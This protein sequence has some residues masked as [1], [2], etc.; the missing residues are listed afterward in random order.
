M[1]KTIMIIVGVVCLAVGAFAGIKIYEH[2]KSKSEEV[3][4]KLDKEKAKDEI[5]AYFH[6]FGGCDGGVAL[7]F[8]KKDKLYYNDLE[9]Y[10]IYDILYSYMV[11]NNLVQ[12]NKIDSDIGGYELS[13]STNSLETA[14]TNIFGIDAKNNFKL[15]NVFNASLWQF[16]LDEKNHVYKAETYATGCE[17]GVNA[18]YL[19]NYDLIEKDKKFFLDFVYYYIDAMSQENNGEVETFDGAFDPYHT[20]KFICK[21]DDIKNHLNEFDKYRY[22]FKLEN[23]HFILDYIEKIN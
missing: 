18:Y 20:D 9:V 12:E 7:D 22:N 11:K 17:P 4:I 2:I 14:L 8:S 3:S 21:V 15:P 13:F 16:N 5:N 1:K 10:V 23:N 19:Y 6:S